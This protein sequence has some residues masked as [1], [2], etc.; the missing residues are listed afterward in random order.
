MCLSLK[1][2]DK[3][4]KEKWQ[5]CNGKSVCE[6]KDVWFPIYFVID[7]VKNHTVSVCYPICEMEVQGFLPRVILRI[8]RESEFRVE[9]RA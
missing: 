3:V 6:R 2:G 9:I 1:L 4:R 5:L 7:T 8:P